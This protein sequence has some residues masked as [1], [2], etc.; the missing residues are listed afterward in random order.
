MSIILAERES[1]E[2]ASRVRAAGARNL[3]RE[4]VV[5][6]WGRCRVARADARSS[7]RVAAVQT[8]SVVGVALTP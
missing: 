1:V 5:C 3:E 7:S 6:P 4:R 8:L 2:G